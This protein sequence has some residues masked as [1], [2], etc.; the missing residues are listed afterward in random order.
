MKSS[1]LARSKNAVALSEGLA[2]QNEGDCVEKG[3]RGGES[4]VENLLTDTLLELHALPR[5]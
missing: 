5:A 3:K 1:L 4:W 2:V